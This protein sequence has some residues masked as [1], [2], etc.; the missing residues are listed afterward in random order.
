MYTVH[1]ITY[2]LKFQI[3]T[4]FYKKCLIGGWLTIS[5]FYHI[6]EMFKYHKKLKDTV[7]LKIEYF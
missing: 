2:M 6:L 7:T 5:I 4:V 1:L 3:F